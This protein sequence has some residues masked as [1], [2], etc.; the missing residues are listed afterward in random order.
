MNKFKEVIHYAE[1]DKDF[2]GEYFFIEIF[3]DDQL[4]VTYGDYYNDKGNKNRKDF[5]MQ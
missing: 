5:L 4:V 3:K 2:N 1:D